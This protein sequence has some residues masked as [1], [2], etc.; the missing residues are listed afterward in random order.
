[1][2][3]KA[4][5]AH[6]R[7]PGD[8]GNRFLEV[9][10]LT[11]DFPLDS[12]ILRR[13][14]MRAVNDVSFR[15]EAGRALAVVGESGSGKSTCAR[16]LARLYQPTSGTVTLD[17]VDINDPVVG[18]SRIELA[19]QVQMIFQDPF[20][21]LNPVHTAGHHL[22]RPLALHYPELSKHQTVE[23]ALEVLERVG[24]TPPQTVFDK[25]PH[26]LSGGQRQRLAIARAISTGASFILADEPISMLDVSIRLGILN[27]MADMK[28]DGIGFLYI[29]HDIATARYFSETTAV[30]YVGHMVE[31]GDSDSVTQ[32][33]RH[34][35]TQLLINAVPEVGRKRTT[36]QGQ[37]APSRGAIPVWTP[38]SR[39]CPFVARCPLAEGRCHTE[40]PPVTV[41]E[42]NHRVRCFAVSQ[43]GNERADE[44]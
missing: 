12:A 27:L 10:G 44:E 24:L 20:G 32:N 4:M 40:M 31:W 38:D 8:M 5:G 3:Q 41:L 16:A 1:V 21:S 22:M 35:Y 6:M 28:R 33:P 34:P 26:E 19:R 15:L 14:Y 7:A 23:R 17:G 36:A 39:G 11:V 13:R 30:M 25:F 2:K 37:N 42:K 29:T 43:V 18:P 9:S